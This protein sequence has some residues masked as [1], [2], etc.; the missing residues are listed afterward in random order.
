MSLIKDSALDRVDKGWREKFRAGNNDRTLVGITGDRLETVGCYRIPFRVG[1]HSF[2]HQ[3]FVCTEQILFPTAGLIGQDILRDQGADLLLSEGLL[4]MHCQQVPIVNWGK[5]G[6]VRTGPPKDISEG[7]IKVRLVDTCCLP[8]MSECIFE[9]RVSA[10][11]NAGQLAV[12][13][14]SDV[15][16]FGVAIVP[17]LVEMRNDGIVPVWLANTTLQEVK[18]CRNKEVGK[19]VDVEVDESPF[20]VDCDC[21]RVSEADIASK[22]DLAHITGPERETLTE[23]IRSYGAAF[24]WSDTDIGHCEAIKHRIPTTDA[25]P[26]YRRAYRIPYAKRADMEK[27]VNELLE[28]D[29]IEHSTSPWGAPALLVRKPDGSYRFVVDFRDLNKVTRVDPYPLP[30][31]QETLSQL[32]NAKFFTVVD[33]SSGYWQIEMDERDKEKTAFN[34]PSGHHQWKRMPMGVVNSA[35]VWQR[36]RRCSGRWASR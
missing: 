35:S 3:C 20:S 13:E 10:A 31:I 9:G 18:L 33:M 34:T 17:A 21:G 14:T 5:S 27:Q 32:G 28:N 11:V 23:L 2:S 1:D 12:L 36:T 6:C 22:F 19:L 30:N 7:S 24:S 26:V 29:I 8:P 4:R 25:A 15:E 16:I